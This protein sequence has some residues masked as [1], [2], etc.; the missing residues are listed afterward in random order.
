MWHFYYAVLHPKFL[1]VRRLGHISAEKAK[2]VADVAWTW[3]ILHRT[4]YF[5]N[6]RKIPTADIGDRFR[7]SLPLLRCNGVFSVHSPMVAK[8]AITKSRTS[9]LSLSS[10]TSLVI[11]TPAKMLWRV[12]ESYLVKQLK[13]SSNLSNLE[14]VIPV[15]I[16]RKPGACGGWR[17]T[18][19]KR[20]GLLF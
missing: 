9:S 13:D 14:L 1:P 6:V 17:G 19:G 20:Y 4:R 18:P 12:S 2:N 3:Q 8:G 7:S 10:G 5:W 11:S 15:K 16:N